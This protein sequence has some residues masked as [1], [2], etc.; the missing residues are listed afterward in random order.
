MVVLQYSYHSNSIR[1][2]QDWIELKR[3][4]K[5]IAKAEFT[6][7]FMDIIVRVY[8]FCE[9]LSVLFFFISAAKLLFMWAH[10]HKKVGG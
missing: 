5:E 6:K 3:F 8:K 10:A 1:F 2:P 7:V 9:I 4:E